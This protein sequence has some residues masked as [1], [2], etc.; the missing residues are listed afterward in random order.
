VLS[1]L[2]GVVLSTTPKCHDNC[3]VVGAAHEVPVAQP[4]AAPAPPTSRP[5][6]LA[7]VPLAGAHAVN[8][9]SPI[10]VR[11][12]AGTIT[13]VVMVNDGG[14]EIPGA[15]TPDHR[16]WQPSGQLGYGRE[17]TMTVTASGPQGMP[18]RQTSSFTTLSANSLTDVYLDTTAGVYLRDGDTYG[19]G[20]VIVAKFDEPVTDKANAERHLVV[21]TNPP[22][23]GAWNWIDDYTA[24]FRPAQY[25]APGTAITVAAKVVGTA[26][27]DGLYGNQD[28]KVAFRIGDA[29]VSIADDNTK[30]VSVFDNGQ[31][32]RTMPTSMGMGG[33][34]EIEGRTLSFFTPPGVYTVMDKANPVIMDSSTFGLPIDS[35]L[36][37]KET[38]SYATRISPDGIYL[39]QLNSTVWAQGHTD[40]SHGCLNLNGENA[41]WFFDFS[42]PG[43]IVEVH[44]TGG[45]PLAIWQNGDWT[46][47][48]EQW[49]QGSKLI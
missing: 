10:L 8:P 31:L 20:T 9:A 37:Y 22:V 5:A 4:P 34:Q 7:I 18:T 29:H 28:Q 21:T 42:V 36:G 19:V 46:I 1:V 17:Y 33:T 30:Q 27:G 13:S 35:R 24:H 25:Y 14:K 15:L 16:V 45:A 26:L 41:A 47:P 2:G 38:I 11:A 49:R 3:Q 40:T 44:N 32:M 48:W 23:D 39:H 6:A 12:D 43:D